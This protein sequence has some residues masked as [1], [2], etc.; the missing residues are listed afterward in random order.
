MI[1]VGLCGFGTMAK[2]H[3]QMLQLHDG[4]ELVAIADPVEENRK[5]AA[6]LYS[7]VKIY[8]T[9]EEL[10]DA[11]GLDVVFVVVPT[12]LHNP[13]AVRA[14]NEGCH[15]FCEKP[16]ALNPQLCQEMI[17]AAKK[18]DKALMIGQV[19]RF[20]PEYVFLKKTIDEKL[21]GKLLALSMQRVGDVSSGWQGWYLDEERGGSQLFDRHLH[22]ADAILWML[23]KPKEVYAHGAKR[24]PRIG[25][26]VFHSFTEYYYNDDVVVSAEGSADTVKGFPFTAT[27][28]ATFENAV[29]EFDCRRNPTVLVYAGAEPFAPEMSGGVAD[30]K[31]GMNIKNAAPYFFEECYF[32]DC[33]KKGIKPQT[34]TP[35]SA[36]ESITMIRAEVESAKTRKPVKLQ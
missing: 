7:G 22:D 1:K 29:V 19:L 26:G 21:Y 4:V 23:G 25:G 30:L 27:Y 28:R 33:L 16:M 24:D 18:A 12:Y 32:F 17:D 20:W 10:I 15:V 36:M 13:L 34:V 2:G 35:E 11:G 6:E 8:E 31:S 9:G 3:A 5:K 14:L